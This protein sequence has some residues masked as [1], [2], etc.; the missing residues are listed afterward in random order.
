MVVFPNAKINIGLKIIL[1][2]SDG[3]HNIETLFYP[4]M[5]HDAL[6]FVINTEKKGKDLL[7]TSGLFI[8][9][10]PEDNLVLKAVSRLREN[11]EFPFLRIHLHK[12][13]PSGAGLGGGSS[14]AACTFKALNRLFSLNIPAPKLKE[15]AL[16]IGSDCPF[17]ID[18]IPASGTG[19]GELL[20]PSS[21]PLEGYY[22]VLVNPGLH[23]STKEA[24]QN[25]KPSPSDN[26]LNQIRSWPVK[27]WKNL[28]FND[29]EDFASKKFPLIG[30]LKNDLYAAGAL[31]SLMSGSGSSV[32]GIFKD[33]PQ[34]PQK[35]R[36]YVIYNGLL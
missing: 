5:L 32:F 11:F 9:S 22:L 26:F 7:A 27:E 29:F 13:I 31:F 3:Y 17:F 34:I 24:Y 2:R 33:E 25:C 35:L 19:R 18:N 4:L 10:K 28:V 6:E 23:V 15:M 30:H 12:A 20:E 36:R 1:K 16:E 21:I 14:D 8:E